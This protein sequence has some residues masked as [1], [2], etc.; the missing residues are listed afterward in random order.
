MLTET[1]ALSDIISNRWCELLDVT[2][3][4]EDDD[5][6]LSGGHSLLAIRLTAALREDL[7]IKIPIAA[8]FETR[9]FGAFTARLAGL[10]E[11]AGGTAVG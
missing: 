3:P 6:F 10:L 9:T 5:F 8:I 2:P 11:A 7:G 1:T 4:A